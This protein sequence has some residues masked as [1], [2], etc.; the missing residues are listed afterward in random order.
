MADTSRPTLLVFTLGPGREQAFKRCLGG[1]FAELEARLHNRCLERDPGRG[2]AAG[3]R[4][5]VCSPAGDSPAP[6]A[7]VDRQTESG[8][9]R[10]LLG[11]IR[12]AGAQTGGPLIVVGSDTPGLDAGLLAAPSRHWRAILGSR[13]RPSDRWRHLSAGRERAPDR[14]LGRGAVA[15]PT[16]PRLAVRALRAAGRPV[17]LLPARSD[18]DAV[19]TWSVGL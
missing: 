17:R 5:R 18:V 3:C 16:N 10:R 11:A 15:Q 1:R 13:C 7:E 6:D 19:A 2:R 8:F 14:R 4:L 12:R 9:G